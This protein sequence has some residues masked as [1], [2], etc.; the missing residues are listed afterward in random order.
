MAIRKEGSFIEIVL[1]NG[2]YAYGRILP[3]ADFAFYDLY[4]DE[5]VTDFEKIEKNEILFIVAVYKDAITKGRWKKIGYKELEPKLSVL[6]LK[7]I[8][9]GL[10]PGVYEIYN[11]NTGGITPTTKDK[12]IGLER[13]AVWEPGHVEERIVD[14][15]EGKT[16]RWVEQLKLK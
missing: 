2:K 3:K 1:P 16:N 13:S 7:F 10:N 6:P 9:D 11:P 4:A 15:F 5:Q 8:E 12:C 14:H